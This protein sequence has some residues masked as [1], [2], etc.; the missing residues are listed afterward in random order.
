MRIL[1]TESQYNRL[2][3]QDSLNLKGKTIAPGISSKH[4]SDHV[5][6]NDENLFVTVI[7]KIISSHKFALPIHVRGFAHFLV[8]R[9]TP[10]TEKDMTEEERDFLKKAALSAGD[11]GLTTNFWLKNKGKKDMKFSKNIIQ[12]LNMDFP[13]QF[14]NFLGNVSVSNIK[15][16]PYKNKVTIIDNYDMN[17]NRWDMS[18]EEMMEQLEES[19]KLF[20][21][22]PSK[23]LYWLIRSLSNFRELGGYNGYP[24]NINL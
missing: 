21:K 13:D 8:G 7:N 18:K 14:H 11:K 16:Q 2:I 5:S 4:S 23:E 10:F 17:T 6:K 12:L 19:I 22:T 1:I 3:E 15:I 9:T 24:I 20:I